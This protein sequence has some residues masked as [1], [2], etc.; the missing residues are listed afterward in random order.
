MAKIFAVNIGG[1][2]ERRLDL[3]KIRNYLIKNNYNLVDKPKDADIIIL[4]T[5]AALNEVANSTLNIIK[6]FQKYDAKLIIGGCLPDIEKKKL[7][8]IFDGETLTTKEID[9]KIEKL[10][11]PINNVRYCEI[12]DSNSVLGV[13]S[14]N[15]PNKFFNKN[16]EKSSNKKGIRFIIRNYFLKNLFGE[17]SITY[18]YQTEKNNLYHIRISWGCVGNCA[19]CITKKAIGPFKSKPFEECMQEFKKGLKDGYSEFIICS[20][21]PGAYGVDIKNSFPNLLNEMTNVEG[22]YNLM[23]TSLSPALLIN[24]IDDFEEILKKKKITAIFF[25]IQSGSSRILKLMNR[26]SDIDK[27][28]EAFLRLKKSFPDLILETQVI[29]GFPTETFEDF[30]ETL[31]FIK[32]CNFYSGYIYKFSCRPGTEAEKIEP[33]ISDEEMSKRLKYAKKFFR[34]AGYK[35]SYFRYGLSGLSKD[36]NI[37]YLK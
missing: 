26:Y 29:L 17:K 34:K 10:F 23:I 24:Y 4:V 20:D 27:M 35:M 2:V 6:N 37:F 36:I 7:S 22:N 11:P 13:T 12:G 16:F 21:D 14:K 28:K 9:Q 25:P 15:E 32:E 5:C 30:K 3:N 8:R 18:K 33:K 1:C 31:N 19:F